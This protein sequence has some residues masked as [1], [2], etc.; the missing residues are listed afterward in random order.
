MAQKRKL[1]RNLSALA[2]TPKAHK[3]SLIHPVFKQM[4]GTMLLA[5]NPKEAVEIAI[6]KKA[7]EWVQGAKGR[8]FHVTNNGEDV[9]IV[10]TFDGKECKAPF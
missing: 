10:F 8:A 3:E 6:S 2:T 9:E 5:N 1:P 4:L 7:F